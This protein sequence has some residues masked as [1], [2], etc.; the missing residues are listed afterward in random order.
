MMGGIDIKNLKHFFYNIMIEREVNILKK[1]NRNIL[2]KIALYSK[3]WQIK[4]NTEENI[5]YPKKEKEK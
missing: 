4:K 5:I 1:Y 2:V 3:G